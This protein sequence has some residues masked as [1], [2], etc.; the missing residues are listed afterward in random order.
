MGEEMNKLDIGKWLNAIGLVLSLIG[1]VILY[2][3][4]VAPKDYFP[5]PMDGFRQLTTEQWQEGERQMK[6]D[7]FVS[8]LG[9]G[10]LGLGFIFQIFALWF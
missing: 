3:N 7:R 9:F 2:F 8:R 4:G 10:A 1:A 5:D 6:R